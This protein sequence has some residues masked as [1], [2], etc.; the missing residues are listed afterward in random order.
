MWPVRLLSRDAQQSALTRKQLMERRC[1]GRSSVLC[2]QGP[3]PSY[4]SHRWV[5]RI[6][7]TRPR[8]EGLRGQLG[9]RV[10]M[11]RSPP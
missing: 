2:R 10:A 3:T 6:T 8:G 9:S 4:L 5:V 11:L 7:R 1:K